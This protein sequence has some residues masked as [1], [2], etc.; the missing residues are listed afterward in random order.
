LYTEID[1]I[2]QKLSS[3]WLYSAIMIYETQGKNIMNVSGIYLNW[4]LIFQIKKIGEL[5]DDE[6]NANN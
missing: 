3:T 2:H 4:I 5:E 6:N 1:K